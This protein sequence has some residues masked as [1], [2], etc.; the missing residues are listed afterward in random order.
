MISFFRNFGIGKEKDFFVENLSVLVSSGMTIVSAIDSIGEEM[1]SRRMKQVL[2]DIRK[3]VEEG[4]SIWK[5]LDKAGI[6]SSHVISLI[7]VGEESGKLSE[8][9]KVVSLQE[10]KSRSFRSKISSAMM[11]PVFVLSITVIVGIS[12]AWFILP[13]LA[14]VFSQLNIK[15][16]T[17]TQGLISSGEFLGEYGMTVVPIFVFIVILFFYFIF[18]FSKTKFIGQW[19]FFHIPGIR[20][21]VKEVELARFGYLLGA[22]LDAGLPVTD[23]LDSLVQ[24][25]SFSTY[26][27]IYVHLRDNIN[28]GNSFQK[29]LDSYSRIK[30]FVPTT[31]RQMVVAGEQSGSLSQSLTKIGEI[32]EAKTEATTKNLSV[33]LEPVLLVIVWL[34]VVGVAMAVILPIYDLIGGFNY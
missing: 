25:T 30:S 20:N 10:E 19:I 13:R 21:L 23:A 14:T 6:F 9:L 34:G 2:G 12:I 22:L 16:P 5:A 26:K 7:R 28:E 27:K 24:A 31:V 4:S 32:Y 29:S 18:F 3:D 17:I 1:K 8:N 15:L 11:Y 33:I